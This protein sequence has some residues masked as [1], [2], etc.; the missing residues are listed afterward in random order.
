[1][2]LPGTTNL[3]TKLAYTYFVITTLDTAPRPQSAKTSPSRL[4][5]LQSIYFVITTLD[6]APQNLNLQKLRLA[7]YIHFGVHTL[8]QKLVFWMINTVISGPP[9]RPLAH[10]GFSKLAQY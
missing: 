7:D 1:M 10:N 5:L 6:T 9:S 2:V 8:S 4:H 3:I